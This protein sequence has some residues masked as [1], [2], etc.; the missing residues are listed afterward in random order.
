M[1]AVFYLT[2]SGSSFRSSLY[3]R[4]AGDSSSW[5]HRLEQPACPR[6]IGA[7]TPGFQ[8]TTQDLSVFSFQLRHYHMTHV[9]LSPFVTPVWTPV[10]LAIINII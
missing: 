1:A 5:Y 8:T 6:R 7:V 2:S 10:V 3:S 4:Q 9:L